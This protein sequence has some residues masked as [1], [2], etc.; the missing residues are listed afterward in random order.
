[1]HRDFRVVAS[2]FAFMLAAPAAS[3][4]T[5][6]VGPSG[7]QY[8]Q[9]SAVF[10]ARNLA[11]GDVILVDGN[12]TYS[13]GIVVGED[14]GGAFG[15]PVTIRWRREPGASRP[16]LSGGEHTIK[17]ELSDHVV[18]DGFEIRG[19]SKTCVFSEAHDVV[20]R[21]S[22]IHGCDAHGILG[23]DL[24]SGSFTLE[25]SEIYDAGD[26]ATKHPIYMQ[27]DEVA[28][29]GS[30]FRMRFNYVHDGNGGNLLK[31]RH[32]RNEIYYNWFEGA[33]YQEI[34]LIGPDCETQDNDWTPGL[35]TENSDVVGNV[36][37]HTGEWANAVRIGGDLNGRNMGHVRMANNTI[38]FDRLGSAT[39]VLVQLGQGRL[40]MHN[41]LIYQTSGTGP[42]V[43]RE[44]PASAHEEPPVCAPFDLEPWAA[45]RKVT[46]SN[47][48]VQTNA[49]NVPVEWTGTLKGLDPLLANIAQRNLRPASGSPAVNKG[50]NAPPA[51]SGAPFPSPLLLPA[52]DPPIREKLGY[53]RW[54]PRA[55]PGG[56]DIGALE[57]SKSN[58]PMPLEGGP[59]KLPPKP[60]AAGATTPPVAGQ[61]R[62]AAAPLSPSASKA[63]AQPSLRSSPQVMAM[64]APG[65]WSCLLQSPP[66]WDLPINLYLRANWCGP[67]LSDDSNHLWS[68]R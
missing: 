48:W 55:V 23:A 20:V 8:T 21:D 17:F 68:D 38:L 37:V 36:I 46:G 60:P 34:E 4:A 61:P 29:P 54:R 14:D 59:P 15:S 43:V 27:S 3:A 49:S 10:N 30:V 2:A 44:N 35:K 28:H 24:H 26:A 50:N 56:I 12:A 25:Y 42:A 16:V 13:G 31:S 18:L 22:V 47:N 65:S 66:A 11:P 63:S 62:Q 1:M 19:G 57:S 51:P 40:E 67:G 9:L 64:A 6:T 53:G 45:G 39:A 41:N 32:E 7:R 52:A 5:Y 58:E 33:A